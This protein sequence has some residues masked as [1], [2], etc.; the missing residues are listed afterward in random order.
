MRIILV[1]IM[2][3]CIHQHSQAQVTHGIS[4]QA[5][6]TETAYLSTIKT[7]KSTLSHLMPIFAFDYAKYN[8][9]AF[10][11]GIGYG[12]SA[13][14]IILF[15]DDFRSKA[16]L[17]YP[18]FWFRIRAGLKFQRETT[19]H[20][21][22]LGLGLAVNFEGEYFTKNGNQQTYNYNG[23]YLNDSLYIRKYNPYVE[24]GNTIINSS[25][26]E[27]KFNVFTNMGIRYYPLPLFKQALIYEYSI[28]KYKSIQ[29]HI[30][31]VF[32]CIGLQRNIQR[33]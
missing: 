30:L 7:T 23:Y 13:R 28:N 4:F 12:F 8:D 5:G 9:N 25:F 31:E 16:G 17:D 2:Y 29:S 1:I 33:N 27:K 26:R 18:E 20:L 3:C 32:F 14:R 24:I 6:I 10:W 15:K 19:T 21:P 11:G 22:H